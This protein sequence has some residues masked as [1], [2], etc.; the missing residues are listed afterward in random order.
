MRKKLPLDIDLELKEEFIDDFGDI[1]SPQEEYNTKPNLVTPIHEDWN[2]VKAF[3]V[4][5]VVPVN[6]SKK[7]L[8]QSLPI[9]F[10][11]MVGSIA[12]IGVF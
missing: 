12:S 10:P 1:E 8:L 3:N 11:S 5:H 2:I 6:L 4:F 7:T 9:F